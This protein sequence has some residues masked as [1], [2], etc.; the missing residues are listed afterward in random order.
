MDI[1]ILASDVFE[2]NEL[3]KGYQKYQIIG[4]YE[5]IKEI[6]NKAKEYDKL[7]E[8]FHHFTKKN[9]KLTELNHNCMELLKRAERLLSYIWT[10][11]LIEKQ[12]LKNEDFMAIEE[13]GLEITKLIQKTEGIVK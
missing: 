13:L 5:D 3:E 2:L 12:N 1:K 7:I 10:R 9:T 6:I 11:T 4:K 8:D